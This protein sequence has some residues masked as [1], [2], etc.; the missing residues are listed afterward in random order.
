MNR[1]LHPALTQLLAETDRNRRAV[2]AVAVQSEIDAAKRG[3]DTAC[4][5]FQKVAERHEILLTELIDM[6]VTNLSAFGGK[7][8]ALEDLMDDGKEVTT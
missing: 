6:G 2:L 3:R 7:D 5:E 1:N 8:I 4:R